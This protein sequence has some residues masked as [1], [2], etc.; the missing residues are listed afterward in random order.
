VAGNFEIHNEFGAT[1]ASWQMPLGRSRHARG[2]TSP[3]RFDYLF[4]PLD[5]D[6]SAGNGDDVPLLPPEQDDGDISGDADTLA[7]EPSHA[8]MPRPRTTRAPI[9][10]SPE[11]RPPFPGQGLPRNNNQ[12]GGLL[13]G[14]L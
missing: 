14:L 7:S 3:S 1:A 2:R 4:E 6:E 10:V 9:S 12:R 5:V 13:G 11:S 8:P